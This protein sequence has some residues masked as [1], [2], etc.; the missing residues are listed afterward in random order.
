VAW[1][2]TAPSGGYLD[3]L[4]TLF[5]LIILVAICA[6]LAMGIWFVSVP[7]FLLLV[8]M[9]V[10]TLMKRRTTDAVEIEDFR[11]KIPDTEPPP[12][13]DGRDHS[14]LYEPR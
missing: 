11:K 2:F 7:L 3:R 4:M 8:G 6:T 14:T 5:M 12:G 13:E 1:R 9:G 10:V